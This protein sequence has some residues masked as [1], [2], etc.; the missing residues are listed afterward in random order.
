MRERD[1]W[2]YFF[3]FFFFFTVVSYAHT[4]TCLFCSFLH[5]NFF[6]NFKTVQY[7]FSV[8]VLSL[9]LPRYGAAWVNGVWLLQCL[10]NWRPV[11]SVES[12]IPRGACRPIVRPLPRFEFAAANIQISFFLRC[13]CCE[14]AFLFVFSLSSI[15]IPCAFY[16]VTWWI[17]FCVT[18]SLCPYV[19]KCFDSHQKHRL[20]AVGILR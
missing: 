17:K 1:A 11:G 12:A 14:C 9:V 13:V 2:V 10:H 8:E 18:V 6:L 16:D 7:W 15:Y 20:W 5:A 4:C 3:I 19:L